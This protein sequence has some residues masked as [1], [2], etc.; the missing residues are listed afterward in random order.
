MEILQDV[1]VAQRVSQSGL[2]WR[3]G[4]SYYRGQRV[5]R[6]EAPHD[7]DERF[8]PMTN[9]QQQF[10]E[11][12]LHDAC[13]QEPLIDFRWGNKVEAVVQQA[14]HATV[15]VDTPAGPYTL[16]TEWLIAADGG[17]S[18]LRSA[19]KL[20]MEGASYEG[21]FVI[22]DI[23]CNLPLPTERLAF[24]DPDWNPG[25]TVLVHREPHGMWRVDY[26]L[27]AGESPQEALQ[28]DSLKQ[29]INATL[30][31][32][33][34]PDMEWALDWSSVYSARTAMNASRAPTVRAAIASPSTIACGFSSIRRRLVKTAG[35]DS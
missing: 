27:P 7:E 30:A 34:H 10:M 29:R 22:A 2:P 23:R 11:E 20:Q 3:F 18:G 25:N 15:T 17:R 8:F 13:R 26:Q 6:M 5:F 31:M 32:L 1:G 4:N 19:M 16:E 24:F 14:T 21:H 12:Y 28:A 9:L 33:G 35:S